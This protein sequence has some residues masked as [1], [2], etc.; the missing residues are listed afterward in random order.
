MKAKA[1]ELIRRIKAYNWKNWWDWNWKWVLLGWVIIFVFIWFLRS[2]VLR[3]D[4][5]PDYVVGYASSLTLSEEVVE[6]LQNELAAI[7]E[8]ENGDGQVLVEVYEYILDFNEETYDLNYEQTTSYLMMIMA[9][10][11]YTDY[12][13]WIVE[14]PEVF[15]VK[16]DMMVPLEDGSMGI[17][18]TDCAAITSLD[19]FC[20][21]GMGTDVDW[22]ELL[23]NT[24]IMISEERP[25]DLLQQKMLGN[26]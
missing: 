21:S 14:N 20:D 12:S 25:E 24:T 19:L 18:W 26:E 8:D 22:Q 3:H 17:P 9:D 13:F 10:G 5:E 4:P 6:Q 2:T 11:P 1:K 16:T 15:Q 23:S 7:G